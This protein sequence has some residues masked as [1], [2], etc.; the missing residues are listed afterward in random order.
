MLT[1]CHQFITIIEIMPSTEKKKK[2][3]VISERKNIETIA[4]IFALKEII[5]SK[6]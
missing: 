3:K 6:V 4:N 5:D 2:K 1:W